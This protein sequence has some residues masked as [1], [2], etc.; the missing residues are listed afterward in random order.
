MDLQTVTFKVENSVGWITM[1]RPERF[2]A[3]NILMG[4]E[5]TRVLEICSA[6]SNVRAVVLTGSGKAFCSG[7]DVKYFS[8]FIDSDPVEPVRQASKHLNRIIGDI[9]NMPKPVIALINGVAGGAGISIAMSCDLRIASSSAVFKQAYTG[10]GLVPDGSWCLLVSMLAGYAAASRMLFLDPGYDAGKALQMGLVDQVADP[11]KLMETAGE[12]AG[13]LAAGPT[14]AFA[15]A[16]AE[17]NSAMMS[18]LANQ[19]EFER[20]SIMK[21]SRTE[22]FREGLAAFLAKR[23]P[24]FKGK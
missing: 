11:D 2:N 19:L 12:L 17:L 4:E 3:L 1:N 10:I 18:L 23:K 24:V 5:L 21:A 9:R 15:L 8:E 6:D 13:R 22:D 7:G 16:K 20:N 14:S